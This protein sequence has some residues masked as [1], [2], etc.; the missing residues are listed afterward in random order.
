MDAVGVL[1]LLVIG[2]VLWT[3][4]PE[5]ARLAVRGGL[6]PLVHAL[7]GGVRAVAR[8]ML[9]ALGALLR[10]VFDV[11]DIDQIRPGG[12]QVVMTRGDAREGGDPT[13]SPPV[14]ATKR[15][16]EIPQEIQ[17]NSPETGDLDFIDPKLVE[18]LA[19]LVASG[20]LGKTDAIKIGLQLPSGEKYQRGKAAL[21]AALAGL[22]ARAEFIGE[23]E[24]RIKREVA[25]QES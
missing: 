5:P 17:P 8:P 20:K 6:G 16:A 13:L 24:E 12:R 2:L 7:A 23:R 11:K 22:S 19:A 14:F 1:T 3:F 9:G 21:D 15:I 18:R 25:Q 4:V 10:W